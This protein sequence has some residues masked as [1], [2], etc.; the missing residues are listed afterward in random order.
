[1]KTKIGIKK[2]NEKAIA[3]L[4]SNVLAAEYVLNVKSLNAHW[5]VEYPGFHDSDLF[6]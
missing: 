2:E 6:F 4:L 5:N 1:M 3:C